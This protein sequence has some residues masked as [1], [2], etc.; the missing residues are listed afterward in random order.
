[1]AGVLS[2][3]QWLGHGASSQPTKT[4]TIGVFAAE[5]LGQ[6]FERMCGAYFGPDNLYRRS[7]NSRRAF[8]TSRLVICLVS[9]HWKDIAYQM[10]SLWS[11]WVLRPSEP[12]AL[13]DVW[14]TRMKARSLQLHVLL[15]EQ[16]L[17]NGRAEDRVGLG[18]IINFVL[19]KAGGCIMFSCT[20]ANHPGSTDFLRSLNINLFPA[21]EQLVLSA[22]SGGF[23]DGEG[24]RVFANGSVSPPHLRIEGCPYSWETSAH[25][26]QLTTLALCALSVDAAPPVAALHGILRQ[27]SRLQRLCVHKVESTGSVAGLYEVELPTLDSLHYGPDMNSELGCL[28]ALVRAPALRR[29]SVL[30]CSDDD[31]HILIEC[32]NLLHTAWTLVVDGF[33]FDEDN[34]SR[35]YEGFSQLYKLDARRAVREFCTAIS[36]RSAFWA[37]I[38]CAYFRDVRSE[39]LERLVDSDVRQTR[40]HFLGI[41]YTYYGLLTN[42]D[43]EWIRGEVDGC[44]LR[45]GLPPKWRF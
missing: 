40:L 13:F 10:P 23:G 20:V 6:I 42:E 21:L 12:R 29:L 41:H 1:M 25:F 33:N 27:A 3:A 38:E 35:F 9:P 5:I 30:I 19:A 4:G 44:D 16:E 45:M 24:S 8:V 26:A 36:P 15:T 22:P 2:D 39:D 11:S 31:I 14:A 37:G 34:I 28:M 7:S 18:T 43:E 17:E 32:K